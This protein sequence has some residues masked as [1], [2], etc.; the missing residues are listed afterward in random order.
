MRALLVFIVFVAALGGLSPLRVQAAEIAPP[1]SYTPV[2]LEL[3]SV[4]AKSAAP[5]APTADCGYNASTAELLASTSAHDWL[6]WV[7]KLSG[8]E[9]VIVAGET[10]TITTRYTPKLFDGSVHARA[11]DYVLQQVQGWG[12]P[13]NNI[14]QEFPGRAPA[15][16]GKTWC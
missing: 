5:Q 4:Q 15:F 7:E 12:Y 3:A 8:A 13:A 1:P 9:P 2:P 6:S 11:Y 16:L 14:E 10:Y